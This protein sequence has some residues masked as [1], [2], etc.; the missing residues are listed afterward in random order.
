MTAVVFVT[1]DGVE[2]AVDATDG[3]SL[4]DAAV[5]NAIPG[6]DADCGG[7]CS[8]ATCHVFVDDAWFAR[9]GPAVDQEA[10]MLEFAENTEPVSRLSCQIEIDPSL[11]GLRVRVPA[12]QY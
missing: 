7:T 10:I 11:E 9:V 4:M 5:Q 8:C 2:R 6:I 12:S 3:R 1:A